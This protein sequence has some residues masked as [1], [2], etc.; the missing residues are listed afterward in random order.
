MIIKTP[1]EV[2]VDESDIF[3]QSVNLNS[4]EHSSKEGK[5][6]NFLPIDVAKSRGALSVPYTVTPP[7]SAT[8]T[9]ST[10]HD[11]Q[12]VEKKHGGF[13]DHQVVSTPPRTP[14]NPSLGFSLDSKPSSEQRGS[15]KPRLDFT[16][17]SM[18]RTSSAGSQLD[19]EMNF[20]DH[21]NDQ[22]NPINPSLQS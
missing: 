16:S 1:E 8:I 5:K 20:Q 9:D 17:D 2:N 15:S 14:S 21:S 22:S 18:M 10:H 4:N 12:G 3:Q 6:F 11:D 19:A 13:L 7:V